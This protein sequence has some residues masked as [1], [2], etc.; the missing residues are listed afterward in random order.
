LLNWRS[1]QRVLAT[2]VSLLL[3]AHMTF[4]CVYGMREFDPGHPPKDFV[5]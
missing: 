1:L 2:V 4:C 3:V 5:G